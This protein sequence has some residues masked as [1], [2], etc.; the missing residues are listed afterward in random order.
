L[1]EKHFVAPSVFVHQW[2]RCLCRRYCH[3]EF[4]PALDWRRRAGIAAD[5]LRPR[6]V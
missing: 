4:D 3:R 5:G 1:A 6:V 2:A